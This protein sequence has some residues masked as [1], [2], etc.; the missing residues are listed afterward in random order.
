M[1]HASYSE[2]EEFVDEL[3]WDKSTEAY[4][5][6]VLWD[7]GATNVLMPA[8]SLTGIPEEHR[9]MGSVVMVRLAAGRRHRAYIL[10]GIL[11]STGVTQAICPWGR[12]LA[13]LGFQVPM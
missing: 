13:R 1:K 8:Y 6:D 4:G 9:Y 3:L 7:T 12:T 11:Y 5:R 2:I 10:D